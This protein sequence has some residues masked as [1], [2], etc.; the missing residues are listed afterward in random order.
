M[1]KISYATILLLNVIVFVGCQKVELP[2]FTNARY[3]RFAFS[4]EE[5]RPDDYYIT[6]HSFGYQDETVTS[7]IIKIPVQFQG[8]NLTEGLTYCV[9]LEQE[10]TTLPKECFELMTTQTFTPG[11][12]N[13]DSVELRLIRKTELLQQT[14]VLKIRL[15]SNENF[16]TTLDDCLVAEVRVDDIFGKPAWWDSIID[17]SYLGT[18]S[19]KKYRDF[20]DLTG[21]IEFGELTTEEKRHYALLFKRDL[22]TNPREDENG[23]MSVPIAG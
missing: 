14:K 3:I 18:Y 10:E 16:I 23:P 6:S 1:R 9:V 17:N 13:I 22:E 8:Y 12:G 20:I 21:I 5:T 7:K 19:E 15:V 4:T 2:L 11:I